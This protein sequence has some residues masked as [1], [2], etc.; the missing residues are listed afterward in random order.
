MGKHGLQQKLLLLLLLWWLLLL[1]GMPVKGGQG[2]TMCCFAHQGLAGT[3]VVHA[4]RFEPAKTIRAV[5]SPVLRVAA[6]QQCIGAAVI[7]LD[8]CN[9]YMQSCVRLG[10]VLGPVSL[11]LMKASGMF[12]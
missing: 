11:L 2:N 6:P 9:R 3:H 5:M 12:C 8:V 7:M 10:P 1:Q 4:L